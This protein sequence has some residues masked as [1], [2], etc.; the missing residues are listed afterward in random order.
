[1]IS[2][3]ARERLASLMDDR[4]LELRLRWREVAEAGGISYEALRDVRNGKGGIRR[5]TERAIEAGLQW[6]PG[7]IAQILDGGDPVLAEAAP[8]PARHG[9]SVRSLID[10][11][12]TPEQ[13]APFAAQIRAEIEAA[14]QK[15]RREY[16]REPTGA[17]IFGAGSYEAN[18]YDTP[19]WDPDETVDLLATFRSFAHRNI[20]GESGARTGL[21]LARV[22]VGAT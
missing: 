6:A 7:S 16:R 21:T 18:A 13:R 5:L 8:E 1:M 9:A 22:P 12:A 20:G 2:P 15:Y 11:A 4:R 10:E 3:E 19:A 17:E 14:K